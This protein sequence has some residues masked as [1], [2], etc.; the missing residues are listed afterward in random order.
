MELSLLA[1]WGWLRTHEGRWLRFWWC[2]TRVGNLFDGESGLP[3]QP[4][5]EREF[6]RVPFGSAV[7]QCPGAVVEQNSQWKDGQCYG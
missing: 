4:L 7:I 5:G 3:A 1:G 2:L 6:G